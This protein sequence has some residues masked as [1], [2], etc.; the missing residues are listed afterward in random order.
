MANKSIR[1]TAS[2]DNPAVR[3]G[4]QVKAK[5]VD[6]FVRGPSNTKGMQVAQAL[7]QVSGAINNAGSAYAKAQAEETRK[8]TA[9]QKLEAKN[10]AEAFSTKLNLLMEKQN[11]S[12]GD[13]YG[14]VYA[15]VLAENP[16]LSAEHSDYIKANENNPEVLAYYNFG[17]RGGTEKN[18]LTLQAG[19]VYESQVSE[20]SK[21]FNTALG[22]GAT[23][24]EAL[25]ALD[26]TLL[27]DFGFGNTQAAKAMNDVVTGIVL[28]DMVTD[29]EG[30]IKA[31]TTAARSF[32]ER[33]IGRKE[34]RETLLK[35]VEKREQ[36]AYEQN[37]RRLGVEARKREKAT[38]EATLSFI[39]ATQEGGGNLPTEQEIL[40]NPD[41]TA[42]QKLKLVQHRRQLEASQKVKTSDSSVALANVQKRIRLAVNT[43]EWEKVLGIEGEPTEADMIAWA[44]D[45][46]LGVLTPA[47]YET[48]EKSLPSIL[49]AYKASNDQEAQKV[50]DTTASG[51]K[52]LISDQGKMGQILLKRLT[53]HF[54][55]QAQGYEAALRER[56]YDIVN[57]GLMEI[58]NE[59]REPTFSEKDA[60]YKKA[61]DT[62][63]QEFITLTTS[64]ATKTTAAGQMSKNNERFEDK[65]VEVV[66]E[67]EEAKPVKQTGQMKRGN[68]LRKGIVKPKPVQLTPLSE[69]GKKAYYK[70]IEGKSKEQIKDIQNKMTKKGH[71]IPE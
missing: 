37:T 7:E 29:E 34:D 54:K 67:V 69:E 36:L 43:K 55:N 60:I 28:G 49:K 40:D 64:P 15:R 23:L 47:D 61:N 1:E 24:D 18:F 66:K 3:T 2:L 35:L 8:A 58:Y 20:A 17:V 12:E 42:E 48:L 59:G 22:E 41:Y 19:R 44:R 39:K 62:V 71:A 46:V 33:E 53:N 52:S 68:N 26:S 5:P 65:E 57:Q 70:L 51:W 38:D 63:Q 50:F 10:N 30:N 6:T 21:S 45:N 31:N 4:Y 27:N 9:L 13:T 16:E 25:N 56:Y 14:D 32:L 11:I